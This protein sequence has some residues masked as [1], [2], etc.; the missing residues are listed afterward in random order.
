MAIKAATVSEL[1]PEKMRVRVT[2]DD[3]D[4]FVSDELAVPCYGS[5]DTKH[6][7]MP[8]VG[9]TVWVEE[10]EDG[11]GEGAVLC[12]RYSDSN[13]P[14]EHDPN[15]RKIDFGEGSFIEFNRSTGDLKIN[16]RGNITINGKNIFLN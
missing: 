9:E 16:C 6:Y 1:I 12:S 14:K 8:S 2:Y 13:P 5:G 15:I 7:W 3:R 4:G 11:N 10:N